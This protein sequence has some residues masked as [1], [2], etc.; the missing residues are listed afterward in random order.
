MSAGQY[1]LAEA[2]VGASA[3]HLTALIVLDGAPGIRDLLTR[4]RAAQLAAA[5]Q[6]ADDTAA[7]YGAVARLAILAG[8][9]TSAQAE[10]PGATV[11]L[12]AAAQLIL[13]AIAG[14]DVPDVDEDGALTARCWQEAPHGR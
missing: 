3:D 4:R 12:G 8:R 5:A 13:A 9:L 10:L 1:P 2:A 7:V 11:T 6:A 14:P